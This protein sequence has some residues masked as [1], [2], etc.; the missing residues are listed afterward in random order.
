MAAEKTSRKTLDLKNL[1]AAYL[2][3]QFR[4]GVSRTPK[5]PNRELKR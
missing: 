3:A 1:K 5:S 4:S 2:L